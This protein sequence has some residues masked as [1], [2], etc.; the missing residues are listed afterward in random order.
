M[1]VTVLGRLRFDLCSLLSALCVKVDSVAD[2][3]RQ[4]H[5]ALIP[6]VGSMTLLVD[7]DKRISFLHRQ[8]EV[9]ASCYEYVRILFPEKPQEI[10]RGHILDKRRVFSEYFLHFFLIFKRALLCPDS[11]NF[12]A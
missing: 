3:F 5:E 7:I 6:C 10:F 4:V 2:L 11:Y 1:G 9:S 12:Y 8:I